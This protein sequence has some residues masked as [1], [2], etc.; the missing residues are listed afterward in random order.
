[1][2]FVYRTIDKKDIPV[3]DNTYAAL[4]ED[5]V[6]TTTPDYDERYA[7]VVPKESPKKEKKTKKEKKS[8]SVH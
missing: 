1:M 8:E 2:S 3:G 7:V 6:F 4:S 5:V